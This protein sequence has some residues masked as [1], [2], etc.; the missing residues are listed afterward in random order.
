MA[1]DKPIHSMD[2]P[3][4]GGQISIGIW[5]N[6]VGDGDD[7]RTIYA[8]SVSRSYNDGK[9]WKNTKSFRGVDLPV[10][11]VGLQDAYHWILSQGRG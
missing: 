10:V 1:N 8:V 6:L 4:H 7:K 9:E 5:E 3:T 2:Y 11:I